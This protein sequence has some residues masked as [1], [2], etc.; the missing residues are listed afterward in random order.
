M[1]VTDHLAAEFPEHAAEMPEAAGLLAA[2]I[3]N[4]AKS[5]LLWFKPEAVTTVKWAGD[6][7][8]PV[9]PA[10]PALHPRN[11]FALW[12]ETVRGRSTPWSPG[13]V[14]AAKE[15]RSA[16]VDVALR[17]A[18]QVEA[19]HREL[20]QMHRELETLSYAI[21][22]DIRGPLLRAVRFGELLRDELTGGSPEELSQWA[23]KVVWNARN[24]SGL[25]ER[26]LTYLQLGRVRTRPEAVDLG[27]LMEQLRSEL[28]PPAEPID[29]TIR[30]LPHVQADPALLRL[31]ARELLTNAVTFSAGQET[32]RIEVGADETEAE[33]IVYVRDN[34]RGFAPE[35]MERIFTAYARQDF[36]SRTSMGV[37]LAIVRR[38]ITR[39]HGRVWA[40]GQIGGGATFFF[41][42]PRVPPA[43]EQTP[44][45]AVD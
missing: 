16:I 18:S 10:G 7:S 8:K 37:G 43:V 19:M 30:G 17:H 42:L 34:G 20:S 13:H 27:K 22:H 31:V 4:A 14:T 29:W 44:A 15:M 2:T 11:S 9:S 5:Y 40:E 24:C 35:S 23:E 1:F 33:H 39:L 25:L 28:S 32:V 36:G 3:S 21:S 45:N 26:L 38:A 41:A 12:T 6:P